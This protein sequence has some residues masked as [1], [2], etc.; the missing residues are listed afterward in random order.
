MTGLRRCTSNSSPSDVAKLDDPVAYFSANTDRLVVID[1]VQRAPALF[2]SV[3]GVIDQRR[4]RGQR[5]G[6][7]LLLGSLIVSAASRGFHIVAADLKA[8]ARFVVHAVATPSRSGRA[9]RQARSA[10]LRPTGIRLNSTR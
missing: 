7:F 2:A 5:T 8:T 1:E 10:D 6:Q 3:R 9:C 4:R